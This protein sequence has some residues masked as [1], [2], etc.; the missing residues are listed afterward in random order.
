MSSGLTGSSDS[1]ATSFDSMT[2]SKMRAALVATPI[3]SALFA[4]SSISGGKENGFASKR[5]VIWR[6]TDPDRCGLIPFVFDPDF[7]Y[8]RYTE[9]ALDIPMFFVVRGG[10]YHAG[11]GVTFRQFMQKGWREMRPTVADWDTHLTTL[12]PDVRLK[13][14]IEVPI[15]AFVP[16]F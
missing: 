1:V 3:I 10:E 14:I 6:D 7:G 5:L 11:D 12:F 8:E 2:F 15:L 16:D 13:R 4:N 9:W